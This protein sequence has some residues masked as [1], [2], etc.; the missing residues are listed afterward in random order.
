MTLI[1]LNL[2]TM[3]FYTSYVEIESS[4]TDYHFS[5]QSRYLMV[6]YQHH[7]TPYHRDNLL[8]TIDADIVSAK[9]TYVMEFSI[10]RVTYTNHRFQEIVEQQNQ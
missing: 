1:S 8:T 5:Q 7:V 6:N 3:I 9:D 4:M 10:H 2:H